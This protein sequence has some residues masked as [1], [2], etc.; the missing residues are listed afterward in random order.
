[1]NII[2]QRLIH[3]SFKFSEGNTIQDSL[4]IANLKNWVNSSF[5]LTPATVFVVFDAFNDSCRYQIDN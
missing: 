2:R 1:M 4:R 3:P 5:V